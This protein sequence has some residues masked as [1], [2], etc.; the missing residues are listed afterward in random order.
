MTKQKAKRTAEQVMRDVV[1]EWDA[2]TYN[3][4]GSCSDAFFAVMME[5]TKMV[6]AKEDAA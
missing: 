4:C 5:A 3:Q 1:R 2:M 6:K